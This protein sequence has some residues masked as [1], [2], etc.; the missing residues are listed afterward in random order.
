M[1]ILNTFTLESNKQIKINFDGGTLS[2]DSGLFLVKEFLNQIHFGEVLEK[3]F[4]TSDSARKRLHTDVENLLQML[5]Q[6]FA[7]YFEDDRADSLVHEPVITACIG[8]EALASQ[9]TLSRFFNRMD[10][11]TL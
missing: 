6:I 5:Y 1:D 7:A 8:K 2:S 10:E 9:P 4:K 11:N 3:I